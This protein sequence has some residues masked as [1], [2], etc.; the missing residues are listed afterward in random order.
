MN[1]TQRSPTNLVTLVQALRHRPTVQTV[2]LVDVVARDADRAAPMI[3]NS[4]LSCGIDL[5]TEQMP[6]VASATLGYWVGTGS[7]D[8]TPNQAGISHFLE[9]LLFKG[10]PNRSAKS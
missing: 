1:S 5:V 9:H 3:R 4:R 6:G 2:D 8:E 7:R 10:T